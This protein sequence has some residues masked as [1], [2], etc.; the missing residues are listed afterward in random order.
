MDTINGINVPDA[1][2]DGLWKF[3]ACARKE[4]SR[5]GPVMVM[6][7]PVLLTIQNPYERVLVDSVRQPN[8]Y[9]HLAEFVWMMAGSNDAKWLSYYNANMLSFSDDGKTF[10]AAYGNRWRYH[11]KYDQIKMVISILKKDPTTRRACIT[12]W[13]PNVDLIQ[14]K[15]IPCNTTIYFRVVGNELEMTVCNRSND[16]IWGMMGAN[17]VHMTMLQEF[18]ALAIGKA[19]GCYRVFTNNLH[20]YTNVP[21]FQDIMRTLDT[22]D[23]YRAQMHEIMLIQRDENPE[24]FI[25]DCTRF[26]WINTD[27]KHEED[28]Y[29]TAWFK[30]VFLPMMLAYRARKLKQDE[31]SYLNLV[32]ASD[33]R[34]AGFAWQDWRAHDEHRTG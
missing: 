24:A 23:I 14:G 5:N 31:T 9:F 17:C 27:N 3:R 25:E 34:Y 8:P 11:F 2:V 15:D 4:E 6:P 21:R 26:V 19:V 16:Y 29:D 30:T 32:K 7:G 1:Y 12:M 28:R 18:I 13:D 22:V 10:A 33:W 20:I